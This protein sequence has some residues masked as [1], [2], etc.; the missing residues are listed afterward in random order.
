LEI[1]LWIT[2]PLAFHRVPHT[3]ASSIL[4]SITKSERASALNHDPKVYVV[5]NETLRYTGLYIAALTEHTSGRKKKNKKKHMHSEC[6]GASLLSSSSFQ[7][8]L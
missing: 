7:K 6:K 8:F 2:K 3:T 5:P 1:S 4:A